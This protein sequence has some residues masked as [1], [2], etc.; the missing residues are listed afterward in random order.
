MRHHS[1][2]PL[3]AI[4]TT[5]R[6]IG[7]RVTP[8]RIQVLDLLQSAQGPLS[9]SDIEELLSKNA[10]PAMDRVTLYRVLD[11]L[12]EVGLAHKAANTRG[13]FCFT[14]AQPNI[15]HKRHIHFRCNDCGRVICLDVPPPL[16]PELPKGFHIASVELDISGECP[17]CVESHS[18]SDRHS[19]ELGALQ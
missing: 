5:I 11:W 15:E 17:E 8:A 18:Y 19:V 14:A 1:D 2:S 16:P 12:V 10:L 3:S 13:V 9:H 4:E 7:A 6:A